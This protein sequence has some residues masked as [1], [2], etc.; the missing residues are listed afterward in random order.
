MGLLRL[1]LAL[2]VV[3]AHAGSIPGFEHIGLFSGRTSVRL[4]FVI[5]GFYMAMVLNTKY[6]RADDTLLFYWN[7]AMRLMPTYWIVAA[8]TVALFVLLDRALLAERTVSL[9]AWWA[10]FARLT[11]ASQAG[12]VLANLFG[13][14]QDWLY[15]ASFDADGARWAPFQTELGHNGI[16]YLLIPPFFTVALEIYFYLMAP[17]TLR[18][19][20]ARPAAICAAGLGYHL[21]L[22]APGIWGLPLGY[23]LFPSTLFFFYLGGSGYHLLALVRAKDR[24]GCSAATGFWLVLI[25]I[26]AAIYHVHG[27]PIFLGCTLFA[28]A[29]PVLFAWTS[30]VAVDR[31]AGELS[32][33]IYVVHFPV[34]NFFVYRFE[35]HQVGA[36]TAIASIGLAVLL[37]V[38][39]ERPIDAWRQRRYDSVRN[40]PGLARSA[41]QAGAMS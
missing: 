25:G 7:R 29:V 18:A 12:I 6:R 2:C 23:H 19:G 36:A 21:L 41:P 5:S 22:I 31:L 30:K 15:L 33:A 40:A 17:F 38:F 9:G 11:P 10:D 27:L 20:W 8:A 3:Q 14:G 4:F 24:P 34:M 39:V 13:I 35:D 1:Y 16:N 28:L 37:F 26:G 32:Y